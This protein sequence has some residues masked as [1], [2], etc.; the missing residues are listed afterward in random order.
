MKGSFPIVCFGKLVCRSYT[1]D[2]IEENVYYT[3]NDSRPHQDAILMPA[4]GLLVPE[5]S[6]DAEDG[7]E[8]TDT[9]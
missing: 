1:S 2:E 9:T 7:N 8:H 6:D 5:T 4:Y 3:E